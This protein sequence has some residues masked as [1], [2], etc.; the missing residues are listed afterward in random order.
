MLVHKLKLFVVE[1]FI[2]PIAFTV[3]SC[4]TWFSHEVSKQACLL[5]KISCL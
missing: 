1:K 5:F 3:N 2:S 4:Y